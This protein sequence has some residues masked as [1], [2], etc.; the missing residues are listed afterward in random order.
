[1]SVQ[2][3]SEGSIYG[4]CKFQS[5]KLGNFIGLQVEPC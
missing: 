3:R 5:N 2:V 1:M 4:V